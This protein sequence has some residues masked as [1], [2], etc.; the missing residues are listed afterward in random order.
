MPVKLEK[1]YSVYRAHRNELLKN[2]CH[3]YVLIKRNRIVDCFPTY[4]EAL[5]Y[6]LEHFGNVPFFIKMIEKEEEV[7]TSYRRL[8]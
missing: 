7:C 6:G 2:H 5:S 8:V 1:E 3:K 4:E